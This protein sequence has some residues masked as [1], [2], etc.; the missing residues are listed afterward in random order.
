[1]AMDVSTLVDGVEGAVLRP[2]DEGYAAEV[3]AFNV[4]RQHT[5]DVVVVPRSADDVVAAVR[6]AGEHDLPVGVQATG[7]GAVTPISEGM[8]ISTRGLDEVKID[9]ARRTA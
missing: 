5:P 3:A 9:P 4:S 6:W 2:E 7:H 1:M 8:L